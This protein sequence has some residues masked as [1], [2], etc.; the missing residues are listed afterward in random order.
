MYT[1]YSELYNVYCT[2][3]TVYCALSVICVYIISLARAHV[4][5]SVHGHRFH[6]VSLG[7]CYR[8][9]RN[10]YFIFTFDTHNIQLKRIKLSI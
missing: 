8:K 7:Y 4:W 2:L 5:R 9:E 6:Q 10:K 1:V 3:Y